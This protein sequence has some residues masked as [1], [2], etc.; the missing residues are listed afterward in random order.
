M[1]F[2]GFIQ[3]KALKLPL[4]LIVHPALH[5]RHHCFFAMFSGL[6]ETAYGLSFVSRLVALYFRQYRGFDPSGSRQLPIRRAIETNARYHSVKGLNFA[7]FILDQRI[8]SS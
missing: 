2:H 5:C 1:I 8:E 7:A 3:A 4:L 6:L